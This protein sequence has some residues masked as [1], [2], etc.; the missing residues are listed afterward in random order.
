MSN[1]NEGQGHRG[2]RSWVA[3]SQGT[4]AG[5]GRRFNRLLPKKGMILHHS[6]ALMYT[7]LS[8]FLPFLSG[9]SQVSLTLCCPLATCPHHLHGASPP[10]SFSKHCAF[11]PPTCTFLPISPT[12]I[13]ALYI[14]YYIFPA[15]CLLWRLFICYIVLTCVVDEIAKGRRRRK[16]VA[17]G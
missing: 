10:Q 17:E 12:L 8:T 3:A 5:L 4:R 9:L 13:Q 2:S 14:I 1:W 15:L 6:C 16:C 11:Y 7:P